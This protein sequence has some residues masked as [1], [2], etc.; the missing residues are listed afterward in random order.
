MCITLRNAIVAVAKICKKYR[1]PWKSYVSFS[2]VWADQAVLGRFEIFCH[3]DKVSYFTM[4]DDNSFWLLAK[5]LKKRSFEA[6]SLH[7]LSISWD[8]FLILCSTPYLANAFV[9]LEVEHR[10]RISKLKDQNHLQ[11]YRGHAGIFSLGNQDPCNSVIM[12]ISKI[13][14]SQK[15]S[16]SSSKF[17]LF[18]PV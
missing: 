17:E 11:M 6:R 8:K 7:I 13:F 18:L 10:I 3:F 2:I 14:L 9:K 4:E 5:N 1:K 15:G 16:I 12:D